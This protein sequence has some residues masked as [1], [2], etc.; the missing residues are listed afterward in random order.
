[1]DPGVLSK[2]TSDLPTTET[3][4]LGGNGSFLGKIQHHRP[5]KFLALL[6]L[7]LPQTTPPPIQK[8]PMLE[9][10]TIVTLH[11]FNLLLLKLFGLGRGLGK[12]F[13]KPNH[14][15]VEGTDWAT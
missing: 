12:G 3:S 7:R 1:M 13:Y 15:T 5:T 2:V 11:L 8:F 9:L 10:A 6:K 4:R 14:F